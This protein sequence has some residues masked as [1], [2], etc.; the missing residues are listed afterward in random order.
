MKTIR[1]DI[2]VSTEWLASHLDDPDLRL[3]DCTGCVNE[4]YENE[5]RQ[6][7]YERWH[8]PGAA[9][10]DVA[11]PKGELSD[12][13]GH[14]PFTWP[15]KEQ[16]EL[17]MSRLGVGNGD[18]VVLY[19]APNPVTSSSGTTWAT[20]AWWLMHHFGVNCAI[21]D[22]GFKKWQQEGRPLVSETRNYQPVSFT[23]ADKGH[24]GRRDRDDVL[25]AIGSETVGLIDS[26]SP[27]SYSGRIDRDYGSFGKRKGH[28]P[29]AINVHFES[30]ENPVTGS[31]LSH[32]Q[33]T[34]IFDTAGV[35]RD[36]PWIAYC[37]GGI[38]ATMVG[39]ALKLIGHQ[40]IAIY[41]ASLMEW[42]N[43]ES[44]P[45]VDLAE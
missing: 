34:N 31:F 10:L 41:D 20:R 39:F 4:Q 7:H 8:I 33:L 18:R 26:L 15:R 1:P 14:F 36:R 27:D 22:G 38:G 45:M 12:A 3:F 17:A 23:A 37:G 35:A 32:E 5:G 11:S 44:L 28:I 25:S 40:E 30:L 19:A 13:Q 9:Y 29:G 21:L 6:L 24:W 42:A 43:D 2:L 16:F